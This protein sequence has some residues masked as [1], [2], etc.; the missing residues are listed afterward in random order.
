M[1][2]IYREIQTMLLLG[3]ILCTC[4][5]SC[6][7]SSS[8][9]ALHILTQDAYYEN[10]LL[11]A[12]NPRPFQDV[13][14]Q[15]RSD[16][17]GAQGSVR[18]TPPETIT[19]LGGQYT[20]LN[21]RIPANWFSTV[22][23]DP[24]CG[25]TQEGS[26]TFAVP[27]DIIWVCRHFDFIFPAN[28][29]SFSIY[30]SSP[31]TMS[32]QGQSSF[33]TSGGMPVAGVFNR[34]GA[35]I[36]Q[37]NASSVS[38]D[39][40]TATFPFPT[41]NGAPLTSD[42]YSVTVS[43]Q[44]STGIFHYVGG[45]FISIG[46]TAAFTGAFGVDATDIR[47]TIQIC[48][49]DLGRRICTAPASSDTPAVIVTQYYSSQVSYDSHVIAVGS[50]PVAVKFFGVYTTTTSSS[51]GGRTT[52]TSK[53]SPSNA[54]TVNMGSNTVSILN[55]QTNTNIKNI[56][57]G[58]QP[59]SVALNSAATHAYVPSYGSGT[60]SEIDLSTQSVSRTAA[61]ATSIQSVALDPSG[62]YVWVGGNNSLYK[63][64]LS[65]F[66]VVASFPVSGSI[67]SLAASNTQN[68]LVYTLVQNCCSGSSAYVAN[69]VN[70]SNMAVTGTHAQTT[71]SP[72]AAYTMN[73]TLPTPP[74]EPAATTVSAQ[75][76][77]AFAASSTPTGFVIYELVNHQQIM[78]GTT[79]TPVR[80]IASNPSNTTA[81]FTVPDS[82]ELISV[83]LP[84]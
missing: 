40:S 70:L 61:I 2:R 11:V 83:P 9:P 25:D 84:R 63:V 57:V 60:L 66:T 4:A 33:T 80:G 82:N 67:T 73:G 58:A 27:P 53:T 23:L 51:S 35:L 14:A 34:N 26:A 72:Y 5:F 16:L 68:E 31:S 59:M 81:Y 22:I 77:N 19:G 24:I 54:I 17:P 44:T 52:Q 30:G 18:S 71:A 43:N 55:L 1:K 12:A 37:L 49:T 76:G 64:S 29:A 41:N 7:G 69:E 56:A 50:N 10:G 32:L 3:L 45:N 20:L 78:T 13:S 15:W 74:A 21:A 28:D 65:T 79:P 39:G 8:G 38:P 36:S 75:F 47:T 42:M 46:E 6:G 48:Y 62:N